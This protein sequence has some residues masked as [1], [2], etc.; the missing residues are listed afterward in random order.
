[1]NGL[2]TETF[3]L[4]GKEIWVVGGAGYLGQATV[5]LLEAAGARVLCIDLEN[6]AGTFVNSERFSS[7]VAAATL[8]VRQGPAIQAFVAEQIQNRGVPHGLV[9]LAFASTA[10]KLEELTEQDFDEVNHGGLTATFLLAR[11]VGQEMA[12]LGRG[13][14]VLFSSMYG[15]VS[16]DPAVYQAPMNKNPIEY[17]I[18]KAGIIQ[19]TRYLAVHWGR[20]HV[21][22]NCISPGPFPNPSVQQNEPEFVE[23]LAQKTP[24]GR[25]GQSPEVAGAVV[26]L[27]SDAASYITGQNLVVDGGWTCW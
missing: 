7:R 15:S 3:G 1:M 17:G 25:V 5:R 26:F 8:D 9:N 23:R 11:Q 16:P 19:M 4:D 2:F 6:R 10:K 27:L 20:Q 14:I 22:C 21:R 18:G 12:R 13:S 24:L